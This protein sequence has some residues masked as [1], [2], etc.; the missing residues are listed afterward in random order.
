MPYL[1]W[2]I[3]FGFFKEGVEDLANIRKDL[4]GRTKLTSTMPETLDKKAV[5]QI[6]NDVAETHQ[7]NSEQS[8]YLYWYRRGNQPILERPKPIRPEIKN[9]VLENR[10]AEF[11]EFYKGYQ[12]SHPILYTNAGENESKPI[13]VLNAY[14]RLDG[15]ESKDSDMSDFMFTCGTSYRLTLP[16]DE[17]DVDDAPYFTTVLD[18]RNTFVVYSNDVTEKAILAGTAVLKKIDDQEYKIYSVYTTTMFYKFKLKAD[19]KDFEKA[20]VEEESN[21]LGMI[22]IIEFPLNSNRLG[23]VELCYHLFN[24]INNVGSNRVDGI[25]QFVQALLVFINCELPPLVDKDGK[26]LLGTNGQPL[27][28]IPKSGDAID[29]KGN[30]TLTPD[31]KYLIAQ[32]D[33]SQAQVTKEDLLNAAYEVAGVPSRADRRSGGDT[34]QAVMLRDGWGAAESRAKTT[35]KSFKKSEREYLKIVLRICRDT[36]SASQEI[37]DLALRDIGI[38]FQRTRSDNMLVKAQTFQILNDAGVHFE[39]CA[40]TSEL[41]YDPAAVTAKSLK[42]QEESAQ[43]VEKRLKMANKLSGDLSGEPEVVDTGITEKL[44]RKD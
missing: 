5:T 28:M 1:D 25:E 15:K 23:V 37:G 14:A 26:P 19:E 38:S 39:T 33:Q 36:Q 34:G 2:L 18:P 17:Q 35:E 42:W 4:W 24:A 13:G 29:I 12:F 43:W 11:V 8:D 20:D 7:T 16:V 22:P 32:L 3:F 10:A 30:G 44:E 31:V 9:Y 27:K 40:E 41:F 6:L 21:G